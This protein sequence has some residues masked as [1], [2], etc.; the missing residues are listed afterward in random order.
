M[1][2]RRFV[3]SENVDVI[4]VDGSEEEDLEEEEHLDDD[5]LDIPSEDEGECL[6]KKGCAESELE[7]D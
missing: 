7:S 5:F 1:G 3:W 6:R 2:G 4:E